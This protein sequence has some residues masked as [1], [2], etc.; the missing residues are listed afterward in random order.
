MNAGILREQ[1]Q[2]FLYVFYS[3]G[4]GL[5]FTRKYRLWE[6]FLKYGWVSRLAILLSIIAGFKFLE[7]FWKYANRVQGA[8][9]FQAMSVMGGFVQEVAKE[10]YNLLFAGGMKYTMLIFLEILIFHITR[11]TLNILK[12]ESGDPTLK[13][14]IR[15]QIRML[16]ISLVCYVLESVFSSLTKT[17]LGMMHMPEFVKAVPVF[18]IQCMFTGITVIDNFNEQ[19]GMSIRESLRYCRNYIGVAIALGLILQALFLVPVLGSVFGPF[20]AATASALVMFE[21]SDLTQRE[22]PGLVIAGED[23]V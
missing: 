23:L 10:E 4:D 5:R 20:L 15:A 11:R 12:L 21:L 2:Q 8:N 6:G 9:P 16:K 1:Y 7:V 18:G 22:Q 19:F 3:L 17:G 14:F 13:A